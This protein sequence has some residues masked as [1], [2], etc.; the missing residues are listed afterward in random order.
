MLKCCRA[1]LASSVVG[2]VA[3]SLALAPAGAEEA[4]FSLAP[5]AV[6]F[7]G[8]ASLEGALFAEE[9]AFPGQKRNSGSFAIEPTF[10]AEWAGG[11]LA[12]TLTPFYR[13]DSAD[14][15]RT[16]FDLREAKLDWRRG[17]WEGTVGVDFVFWG[18]TE[19]LHLVDVINTDD[20]VE[21]IDG[22]DKLGQPMIRVTRLTDVG[23]FS[24]F[25]L[26]FFR[27]QTFAGDG[28][29]LRAPLPVIKNARYQVDGDETAPSFALRWADAIG[30]FDLGLS[31]F[32]GVSRDPAL[33]P[34]DFGARLRPVYDDI[35][36]VGFDGQYTS[37]DTLWKLETLGRFNQLDRDLENTDYFA[38]TG[39]LEHTLYGVSETAMDLGL[40]V[41][42]AYDSRGQDAL[43]TFNRDVVAGARLTFNDVEDTAI[44]LLGST[45]VATGS[46]ALRLE[47]ERR[48]ADGWKA[49]IEGNAF[50]N[51][52][53]DD[54][55]A[56]VQDDS[57]LRLTLSYFW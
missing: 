37:G 22:E 26:P 45:D 44:L 16:H 3:A 43:T 29:R 10:L 4:G 40:I 23:A 52:D 11:D 36:Q 19:A 17:D 32:H 50:L 31:A 39:G 35:T 56:S 54:L 51:T 46:S 49:E 14:D 41:E 12:F 6:E 38:A 25:Y 9:P 48:I 13:V 28:G 7:Y 5:E 57:Y 1:W 20:A 21:N 47:A 15:R 34:I 24:V 55:E 30:D 42:G 8:E 53:D 27:E 33:E 2:C 18:K